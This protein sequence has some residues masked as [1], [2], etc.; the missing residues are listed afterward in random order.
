MLAAQNAE[1]LWYIFAF[2]LAIGA[3]VW[4]VTMKMWWGVVLSVA[5]IF[6]CFGLLDI[7]D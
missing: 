6:I 2:I 3:G 7:F 1:K 5:V 4:A